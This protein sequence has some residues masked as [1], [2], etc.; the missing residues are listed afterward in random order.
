MTL[1]ST[2]AVQVKCRGC[3]L[4]QSN[5]LNSLV[6]DFAQVTVTTEIARQVGQGGD[7]R[8]CLFI[9]QINQ[10]QKSLPVNMQGL[11]EMIFLDVICVFFLPHKKVFSLFG[12]HEEDERIALSLRR[13]D[14]LMQEWNKLIN[15]YK[16]QPNCKPHG[17]GCVILD[18]LLQTT[19]QKYYNSQV[20]R[21]E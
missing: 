11:H 21:K 13:I 3:T 12:S 16:I 9:S 17:S 4:L 8:M 1:S 20:S 6:F 10:K 5:F 14:S 15:Q 19:S 2:K 18:A 7:R